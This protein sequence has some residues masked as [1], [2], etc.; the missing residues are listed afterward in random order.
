MVPRLLGGGLRGDLRQPPAGVRLADRQ[1]NYHLPDHVSPRLSAGL[2]LAQRDG[3]V[4]RQ[5]EVLDGFATAAKQPAQ[6]AGGDRQQDVVGL[7]AMAVRDLLD[8]AEVAADE[9][10]VAARAGDAVQACPG[11]RLGGEDLAYRRPPGRDV[12]R[13]GY[14]PG[15]CRE[16]AAEAIDVPALAVGEQITCRRQ[17][18]ACPS[19]SPPVSRPSSGGRPGAA[20]DLRPG[21]PGPIASFVLLRKGQCRV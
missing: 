8:Q 5:D 16:R 19:V 17:R 10:E 3:Y 12:P 4:D 11:P 20:R 14:R 9:G 1:G 6:A 15:E 21:L 2:R 7:G 18:S 13:G